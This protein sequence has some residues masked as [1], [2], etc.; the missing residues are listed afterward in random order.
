MSKVF[1]YISDRHL[2]DLPDSK[3]AFNHL[4]QN[5]NFYCEFSSNLEGN[6][7][8]REMD[9]G[10][11]MLFG[12]ITTLDGFE[13]F[14]DN[15]SSWKLDDYKIQVRALFSYINGLYCLI[16]LDRTSQTT[17][18]IQDPLGFYPLFIFKDS[19][20]VYWMSEQQDMLY[21]PAVK[22]QWNQEAVDS[23]LSNG[24]LLSGQSW[25]NGLFRTHAAG[26]YV[27]DKSAN[28]ISKDTYW[29]WSIVQKQSI[30]SAEAMEKYYSIFDQYIRRLQIK[31]ENVGVSLSGG[32][33]SR[34]ISF[35]AKK[36]FNIKAFTFSMKSSLDLQIAEKVS[37][38]LEIEHKHLE[39]EYSEFIQKRLFSVWKTSGMLGIDHM[40]EG[41]LHESMKTFAKTYFHGFYGG[42]IYGSTSQCNKRIDES[43]AKQWFKGSVEQLHIDDPFY[44]IQNIDPF[45]T[46][47]KIRNESAMSLYLLSYFCKPIIP[48]Y[49]L[50]WM[51]FNLSLP[52]EWQVNNKFYLQVLKKYLPSEL[53][54]LNWQK[55]GVP[56]EH[57][58]MNAFLMQV[59]YS[60][61]RD[62]VF[63][64][65][66]KS[67]HF[68]NYNYADDQIDYELYKQDYKSLT[69]RKISS[70]N[71][72][73]KL[74]LLTVLLF[75]KM[76]RYRT[77]E[78]D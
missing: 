14:W 64:Q 4:I 75:Q 71:R 26:I 42:G 28:L 60:G 43:I 19:T 13:K 50:E 29:S 56:I 24:H 22:I 1:G 37:K 8:K 45:I 12:N 46:D 74:R 49:N 5:K 32:L 7:F 16:Y 61:I 41:G 63:N 18:I 47:H 21:I 66:G 68:F 2:I 36:Y 38:S 9:Q 59:R 55:T 31:E 52:D 10:I 73:E 39:I 76:I 11:L 3:H 17:Y 15:L 40:H 54:S 20:S 25:F 27:F 58:N 33:D 44:D 57:E 62:R 30:D 65:L 77:Y 6:W 23:M 67:A 78:I 69:E 70:M 48:F 53:S 34:F 35:C 72:T 51:T